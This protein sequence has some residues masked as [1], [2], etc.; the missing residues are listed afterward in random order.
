LQAPGALQSEDPLVR[1]EA[2]LALFGVTRALDAAAER[3]RNVDAVMAE[4][5]RET[6]V[7]RAQ[8]H[9]KRMRRMAYAVGIVSMLLLTR[10]HFFPWWIWMFGGGAAAS[11]N[12]LGKR[13]QATHAL[14]QADEPRTVGVLALVMSEDDSY[15][16]DAARKALYRLLPRVRASDAAYIDAE[17]MSALLA[18]A[19]SEDPQM[20]LALLAALEQVGDERALSVVQDLAVNASTAVRN[21]AIECL[22]ALEARTQR[23][24]EQSTLLRGVSAPHSAIQSEQLLR[25]T[26]SSPTDAAPDELLRAA[27]DQPVQ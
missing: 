3:K 2:R 21:R 12:T 10:W 15:V 11:D 4:L 26:L 18:L 9:Q 16:H 6:R 17:Q 23:V 7:L 24:R 14:S 27:G 5:V 20:Q 19:D 8:R 13:R 25:P 1:A 22:P